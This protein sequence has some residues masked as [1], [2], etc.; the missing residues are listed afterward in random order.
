MN[1]PKRVSSIKADFAYKNYLAYKKTTGIV[2]VDLKSFKGLN[3]TG[4]YTS[5][6]F[7][8]SVFVVVHNNIV[9]IFNPNYHKSYDNYPEYD[10]FKR[11]R[12]SNIVRVWINRPDDLHR[13]ILHSAG[14]DG[15]DGVCSVF[16][17]ELK[18]SFKKASNVSEWI[19]FVSGM[20]IQQAMLLF[21]G[22]L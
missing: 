13:G 7:P 2:D 15:S 3:K 1:R 16:A 8:H 21:R 20:N 18:K 10:G 12:G 9:Y 11:F 4:V 14:L 19:E 5:S 17:F 6:K 22:Q